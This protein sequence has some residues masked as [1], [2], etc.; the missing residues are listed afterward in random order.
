MKKF[1]LS[2]ILFSVSF[3]AL[4]LPKPGENALDYYLRTHPGAVSC[5]A[6]AGWF[7][8]DPVWGASVVVEINTK[9]AV[10]NG[11]AFSWVAEGSYQDSEFLLQLNEG[12]E[13]KCVTPRGF[14]SVH[15][16]ERSETG[17]SEQSQGH[18]PTRSTLPCICFKDASCQIADGQST[19]GPEGC[20]SRDGSFK[21]TSGNSSCQRL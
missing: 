10:V 8:E 18:I 13:L 17:G 21:Y 16:P 7:I 6:Q 14:Y 4:A 12:K 20:S 11:E 5:Q 15:Y 1:L 9:T 2:A 3:S 19:N